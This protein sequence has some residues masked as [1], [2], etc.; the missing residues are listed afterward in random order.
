MWGLAIELI[1]AIG[2][3]IVMFIAA[4]LFLIAFSVKAGRLA[5]ERNWNKIMEILPDLITEAEKFQG[6]AGF[7]KKEFVKSRLAVF[8]IKNKI[9]FDENKV[10]KKIDETVKLTKEV[11][12]R[13]KDKINSA[14]Q[15]VWPLI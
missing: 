6:Y 13:E 3:G 8:T 2:A 12:K 11:N 10:D 5:K 7:E 1:A 14:A 9:K 15:N 4:V